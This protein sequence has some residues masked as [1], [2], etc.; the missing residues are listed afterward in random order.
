[1][2]MSQNE[3]RQRIMN[4]ESFL[5]A[6]N[7][8]FLG[9]LSSNP[10]LSEGVMNQYGSFGSMYS[11]TSIFNKYSRYGSEYSILSPF[12][13]YTS[14]PPLI[15]LHGRRV[16]YLSKN[17]YLQGCLDPDKLSEWITNN[18]LMY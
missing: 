10:Y 1:M 8:Q 14:T 4:G 6:S 12:N 9:Q 13:P 3:L 5:V 18:N 2:T 17:I 11:S 16:G 15:Y 7:G